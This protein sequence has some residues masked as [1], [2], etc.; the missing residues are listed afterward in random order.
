MSEYVAGY[1]RWGWGNAFTDFC[2]RIRENSGIRQETI[3][4]PHDFG[5]QTPPVGCG[6]PPISL[7]VFKSSL[8][9]PPDSNGRLPVFPYGKD[10]QRAR[11]WRMKT[12]FR[13]V[14]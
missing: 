7:K 10:Y 3:P 9:Y 11:I 1:L 6:A 8:V 4:K 2:S 12:K 13:P 14:A 5:Y